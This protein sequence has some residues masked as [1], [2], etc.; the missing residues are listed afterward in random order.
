MKRKYWII[1][2]LLVLAL[3]PRLQTVE[4][5]SCR[6]KEWQYG[7]L[8]YYAEHD[9]PACSSPEP[10]LLYTDIWEYHS[11][12]IR[13]S[14][15]VGYCDEPN[16]FVFTIN[17]ILPKHSGYDFFGIHVSAREISLWFFSFWSDKGII[18]YQD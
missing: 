17:D 2:V 13:A 18:L 12:T 10:L 16:S 6:Y 11:L 4:D 8:Y 15:G 1:V 14:F 7:N 5:S 9:A 3:L